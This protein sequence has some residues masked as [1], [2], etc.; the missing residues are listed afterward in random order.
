MFFH[1]LT[2]R[3]E[4]ALRVL[5]ARYLVYLIMVNYRGMNSFGGFVKAIDM[6]ERF[7]PS[8][9]NFGSKPKLGW[10]RS[11]GGQ[12]MMGHRGM[13]ESTKRLATVGSYL[14]PGWRLI[15][16]QPAWL[17][18]LKDMVSNRCQWRSCSF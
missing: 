15:D 17:V 4:A 8:V 7:W 6:R 12:V 16:P 1:K 3:I 14:L 18:T 9:L 10:K 2:L 5:I 11:R 13:K